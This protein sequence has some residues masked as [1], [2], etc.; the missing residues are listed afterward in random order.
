[1]A[2]LAHP[3]LFAPV[4]A[5]VQIQMFASVPPDTM[6]QVV[7]T[8]I[9]TIFSLPIPQ[10]APVTDF[11]PHQTIVFAMMAFLVLIAR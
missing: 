1:M 5:P 8:T 7:K 11:V 4:M 2:C 10:Y 9:A 3:R 6:D